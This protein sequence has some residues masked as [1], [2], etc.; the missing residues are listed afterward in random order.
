MKPKRRDIP[1]LPPAGK[2]KSPTIEQASIAIGSGVL[3]ARA[4]LAGN[5]KEIPAIRAEATRQID[6]T[7][8]RPDVLYKVKKLP[9]VVRRRLNELQEFG[10]QTTI[11]E[12]KRKS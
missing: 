6:K 12:E 7:A 3:Q 9:K 4:A 1:G 8:P 5:E 2:T 11:D 10:F